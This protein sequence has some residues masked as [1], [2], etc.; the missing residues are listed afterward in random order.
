MLNS[1]L[2]RRRYPDAHSGQELQSDPEYGSTRASLHSCVQ[3]D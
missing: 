3:Q 1:I 2:S